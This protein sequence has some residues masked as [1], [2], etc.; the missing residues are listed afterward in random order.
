M[1]KARLYRGRRD[2]NENW[3][4]GYYLHLGDTGTGELHIIV[5]SHGEYHRIKVETLGECTEYLD[6]IGRLI[7]TGDIVAICN[8]P[9][10]LQG[11]VEFDRGLYKIKT[12]SRDLALVGAECE[13]I[14]N[15]HEDKGDV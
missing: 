14:R 2:D 6:T 1:T 4:E 15:S 12:D 5:D 9:G 7:F 11:I 8:Y 3:V 10:S 13:I